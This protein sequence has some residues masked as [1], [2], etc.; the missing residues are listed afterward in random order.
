MAEQLRV[1]SYGG[2]VQSTAMIVLAAQGVIDYPIAVFSNVGDDSEH[3]ATLDYVRN[4]AI[5][6]AAEH[7]VTIHELNRIKR[8]GSVETLFGRLTKEGSRSVGIPVR[9][10]NGAPGN[11]S[12]TVDFKIKVV[13]KW[14][15]Q[16]GASVANPAQVAIGISTDEVQRINNRKTENYQ[17]IQYPLIDLLIDRSKCATIISDAGL[18]VPPK[19]SCF[20]CPFHRPQTWREMRRDEP[21]LFQKSVELERHLN[22]RRDDIGK[23]HVWF[24]RFN[25]P[26]DEA[27]SEAQKGLDLWGTDEDGPDTCDSGHC[28]T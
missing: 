19:S 15:K 10:S 17:D 2:G 6:W 21:E 9:M 14:L 3:P 11:R 20:F 22:T 23:D 8:D 12:C 25:K 27:I 1:I 16:H 18:P 13:G 4:I 5:P 26:L 28:F 24:T 7:G